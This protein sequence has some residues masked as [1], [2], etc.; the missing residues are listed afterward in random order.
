MK[1]RLSLL[2]TGPTIYRKF[3]I[4]STGRTDR[5]RLDENARKHAFEGCSTLNVG[6]Q[7]CKFAE[8]G[9]DAKVQTIEG[10]SGVELYIWSDRAGRL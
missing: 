10:K 1:N 6:V 5:W 7:L 4:Q 3:D 9:A 2:E 8:V